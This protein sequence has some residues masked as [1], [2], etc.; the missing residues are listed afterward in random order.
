MKSVFISY[1][2]VLT[3]RVNSILEELEIRGFTKWDLTEGRGSIDGEPHFGT[4]A[5][6]SMNSSILTIIDD[7]KVEPLL[8]ALREARQVR[9]VQFIYE[10][11]AE[12]R[13]AIVR[14]AQLM[15]YMPLCDSSPRPIF[16]A[17]VAGV[18]MIL[19]DTLRN[20]EWGQ[21]A[22]IY[23][24]SGREGEVAAAV[25]SVLGDQTLRSGLIAEAREEAKKYTNEAIAKQLSEI[26]ESL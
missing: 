26:Y 2:K 24:C 6:P 7:D 9:R 13:L 19:S 12:D 1:N 25:E 14:M 11:S 23:L 5:W 3:D 22:A 20:R 4:H 15:I 10:A 18:P 8:A 16:E 17:M 21:G